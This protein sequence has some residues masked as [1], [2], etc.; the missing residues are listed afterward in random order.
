MFLAGFYWA[1]EVCETR[2]PGNVLTRVRWP[3]GAE[4]FGVGPILGARGRCEVARP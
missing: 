2:Y 4:E 1:G 3:D